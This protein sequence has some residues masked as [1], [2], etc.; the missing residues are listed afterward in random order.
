MVNYFLG[1]PAEAVGL[2]ALRK[3]FLIDASN[4]RVGTCFNSF[5]R[6][7]SIGASL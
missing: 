5:F 4:F 7:S 3:S 1:L 6:P 2:I